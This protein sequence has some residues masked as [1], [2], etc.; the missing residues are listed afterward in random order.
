MN[1]TVFS[2]ISFGVLVLIISSLL[3]IFVLVPMYFAPNKS[4]LVLEKWQTSNGHFSIEVTSYSETNSFVPGAYYVFE[5]VNALGARK[6]IMEF[7]HD[8]Q[9]PINEDGV[10]FVDSETAYVFM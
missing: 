10:G 1:L 3:G 4:D 8:D 6:E 9:V 2:K 5:S 7:R